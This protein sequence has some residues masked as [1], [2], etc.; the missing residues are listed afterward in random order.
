MAISRS[1]AIAY[2]SIARYRGSKMCK[3]MTTWGKRTTFGSGKS[4]A[5]PEKPLSKAANSS[6]SAMT[7]A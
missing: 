2:S 4:R 3:G 5:V 6:D 1:C 7:G